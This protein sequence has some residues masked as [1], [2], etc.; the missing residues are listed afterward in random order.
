MG[1]VFRTESGCDNTRICTKDLER[2]DNR[3]RAFKPRNDS[4]LASFQSMF[5]FNCQHQ[6]ADFDHI[7]RSINLSYRNTNNVRTHDRSK[8]ILEVS[9]LHTIESRDHD[10]SR[11]RE[12]LEM[13]CNHLPSIGFLRVRHR[14]L[15][16]WNKD[17]WLKTQRLVDHVGLVARHEQ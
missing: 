15:H 3:A 6:L 14:V 4:K 2:V 5:A 11:P 17:I 1:K 10:T 9:T 16:V 12:C 7:V 13:I 8:I